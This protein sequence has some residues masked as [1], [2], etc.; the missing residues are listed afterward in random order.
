MFPARWRKNSAAVCTAPTFSAAA[1]HWLRDRSIGPGVIAAVGIGAGST[2]GGEGLKHH[3]VR[4]SR[5]LGPLRV[6][7]RALAFPACSSPT[8]HV[9]GM[10]RRAL[11]LGAGMGRWA[12]CI[13]G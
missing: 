12:W 5:G 7:G 6:Q 3:Q 1:I 13:V 2:E 4:G 8:P 9:P 11:R 10:L